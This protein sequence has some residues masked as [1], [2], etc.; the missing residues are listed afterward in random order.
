MQ[1]TQET[2]IWFLGWEDPLE[3]EMA[4]HSIILIW[5]ILWTEEPTTEPSGSPSPFKKTF[6]KIWT[7]Q[8]ECLFIYI[9][10][11][12]SILNY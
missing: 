10:I 2:W 5:K 9:Y 6:F 11:S 3:E 8:G 12:H 1:K 4:I 7:T